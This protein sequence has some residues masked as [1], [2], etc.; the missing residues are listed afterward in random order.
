L[1]G[2]GIVLGI[3]GK[4]AGAAGGVGATARQVSAAWGASV[5]RHGGLMTG[6]EHIMYRHGA[7]SGFA[8]VSRFAEGTNARS[9]VGYVDQALRS[10]TITQT[11]ANGFIIEANLG[12][13]IGTNIAGDAASSI[14]VFVR[15][16]TIQTA[17]PF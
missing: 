5:Y 15:D 13:T 3:L 7:S 10:G 4:A 16:G 6:I 2:P 17:F 9:I 14:R 11:G 12:R 8:N 1:V